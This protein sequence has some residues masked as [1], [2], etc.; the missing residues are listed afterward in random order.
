MISLSSIPELPQEE[1]LSRLLFDRSVGSLSP[2]QAVQLIDAI[3]RFTGVT[4]G[5]SMFDRI[6]RATGLDDLDVRQNAA[7]ATTVGVG[8]RLGDRVRLGVEAGT[9]TTAGRVTVDLEIEGAEGTRRSG[10]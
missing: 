1:V 2:L 3:A 4:S 10:L 5:S 9:G 7:G 8:R 6:R